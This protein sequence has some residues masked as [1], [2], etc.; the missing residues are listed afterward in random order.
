MNKGVNVILVLFLVVTSAHAST[1]T[2]K[3]PKV[4]LRYGSAPARSAKA[5]QVVKNQTLYNI[6]YMPSHFKRCFGEQPF[7]SAG[8][9]MLFTV[10]LGQLAAA[11][12]AAAFLVLQSGIWLARGLL[13]CSTS[14]FDQ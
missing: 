12:A 2:A 4:T 1:P 14:L 7:R 3:Y 5:F 13:N 10:W 6:A 8:S 9:G 11:R